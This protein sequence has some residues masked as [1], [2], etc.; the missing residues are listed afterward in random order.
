MTFV[1][2]GTDTILTVTD[3]TTTVS[4]ITLDGVTG[5]TSIQDMITHN[6]LI[7]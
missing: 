6:Q 5:L 7:V 2:N 1:D 4:T 3:G